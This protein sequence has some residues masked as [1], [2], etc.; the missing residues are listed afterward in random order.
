[1]NYL[2]STLRPSAARTDLQNVVVLVLRIVQRLA[3]NGQVNTLVAVFEQVV[4][5]QQIRLIV[6]RR[7]FVVHLAIGCRI[8][9]RS[10]RNHVA[11][12]ANVV[13]VVVLIQAVVRVVV[14]LIRMIQMGRLI[15]VVRLL[16]RGAHLLVWLVHRIGRRLTIRW[17]VH[18]LAIE[19]RRMILA[20]LRE[21]I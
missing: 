20:L 4:L 6:E 19:V 10:A 21:T 12:A 16:Q 17:N 13:V 3:E 5:L 11:L 2:L 8:I 7:R 9:W 15:A 14:L 18:R 1:M